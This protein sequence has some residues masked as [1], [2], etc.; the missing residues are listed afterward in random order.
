MKKQLCVALVMGIMAMSTAHAEETGPVRSAIKAGVKKCLPAIKKLSAF[1]LDNPKYGWTCTHV[2]ANPDKGIFSCVMETVDPKGAPT[3]F[4]SMAVIPSAGG[5]CA[6]QY[7][8]VGIWPKSC[9][10]LQQQDFSDYEVK[11]DK[12][13]E[14]YAQL[15]PRKGFA[16]MRPFMMNVSNTCQV[17]RTE[18]ITD[19]N[20]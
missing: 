4:I 17:V 7:T 20:K 10:A 18:M 14:F 15:E 3:E 13:G 1:L 2:Q 9:E 16:A 12:L 5:A 19:L 11:K 8:R 6:G